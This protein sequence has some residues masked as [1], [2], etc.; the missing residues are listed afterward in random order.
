MDSLKEE[1]K[2]MLMASAADPIHN[3]K[4]IDSLLRL[5]GSYHFEN[6]IENQL[7]SIFNSLQKLFSGDG[8]DLN[9]TSIVFRVFRQYGFKMSC[10]VFNKLTDIDG[11]FKEALIHDVKG[12][13]NLYESAHLRIHGE[14]VLE[15]A[16]AFTTANLKSLAKKS[17]PNLAKQIANALDQ[18][19]NKCPPRL[20]T[21]TYVPFY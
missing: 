4:L 16:L 15:E 5:G 12:M 6:D 11:K 20:A 10:D 18:P 2:D 1:V 19:L 9:T 14:N 3:V 7:E 21:R 8:H 13:L 17:S